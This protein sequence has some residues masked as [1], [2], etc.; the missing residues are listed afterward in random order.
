MYRL[1][2][3]AQNLNLL[4]CS[5]KNAA[6]RAQP[7]RLFQLFKSVIKIFN[8]DPRPCCS[9]DFVLINPCVYGSG[10]LSLANAIATIGRNEGCRVSIVPVDAISAN[11]DPESTAFTSSLT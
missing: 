8:K 6:S 9:K 5:G 7:S 3:D 11:S 1:K 4:H 10:D 2:N